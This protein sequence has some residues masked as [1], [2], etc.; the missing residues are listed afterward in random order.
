MSLQNISCK[1]D[2]H[3][4]IF[5]RKL[6]YKAYPSPGDSTKCSKTEP[7]FKTVYLKLQK[8]QTYPEHYISSSQ[9][10][11]NYLREIT[12]YQTPPIHTWNAHEFPEHFFP[13]LSMNKQFTVKIPFLLVVKTNLVTL[14]RNPEKNTPKTLFC[15]SEITSQI[16]R[17]TG[18][19]TLKREDQKRGTVYAGH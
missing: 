15:L 14:A 13:H 8:D 5:L 4:N 19:V 1:S 10:V 3:T 2:W 18:V 6:Q 9:T 12:P 17:F 7:L 11:C 16:D